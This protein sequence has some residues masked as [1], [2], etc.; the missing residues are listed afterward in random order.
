MEEKQVD[1]KLEIIMEDGG[2]EEEEE[3][4]EKI[5]EIECGIKILVL[6]RL[7]IHM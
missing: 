3:G 4:E 5:E 6:N 1:M 7:L 2:E